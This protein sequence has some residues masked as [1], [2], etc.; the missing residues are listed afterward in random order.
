MDIIIDMHGS[1]ILE[2]SVFMSEFATIVEILP[3]SPLASWMNFVDK[4]VDVSNLPTDKWYSPLTGG[5]VFNW[6]FEHLPQRH[7]WFQL[8]KD[9]HKHGTST[10]YRGYNFELNFSQLVKITDVLVETRHD[11]KIEKSN[12]KIKEKQL[13]FTYDLIKDSQHFEFLKSRNFTIGQK[14]FFKQ[15]QM[16]Q[17]LIDQKK[18][19]FRDVL[20]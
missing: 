4:S 12:Y 2:A 19:D 10:D 16:Y 1:G 14:D 6:V 20:V 8:T 5:T 17:Y 15:S 7:V 18:I 13:F 9:E 11:T 3:S